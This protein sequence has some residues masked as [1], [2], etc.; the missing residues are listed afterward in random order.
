MALN[1][2][3][4]ILVVVESLFKTIGGFSALLEHFGDMVG[5]FRFYAL[6]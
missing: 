2:P 6:W 1:Q 3:G 4:V 5:V